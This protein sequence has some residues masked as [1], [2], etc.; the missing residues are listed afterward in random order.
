M[1]ELEGHVVP[2]GEL[3]GPKEICRAAP[4]APHAVL[5]AVGL[6]ALEHNGQARDR[7]EVASLTVI[8]IF[9]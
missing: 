5:R 8:V 6:L 7:R 3:K 9:A 4:T 1:V 2:V